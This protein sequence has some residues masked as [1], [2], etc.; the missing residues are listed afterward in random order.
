MRVAQFVIAAFALITSATLFAQSP[1]APA[2]APEPITIGNAH[3]LTTHG[4]QRRINVL[5]PTDYNVSDKVYPLVVMLD[6]GTAQD[7]FLQFGIHRWNQ[8]WGRSEEAI[9]VGVETVDRQRELLP[10]SNNAE[11]TKRYPSH[12]QAD[13]FRAW[14]K[15]EV[16]P[17]IRETYRHDGRSFLVGESAAGH[18]VAET[19]VRTPALFDGYAALSPSLQ[20]NDQSL[21]RDPRVSEAIARPPMFVSLANERG[22]TQEGV[23]RFVSSS[24]SSVCF[25]DRR[26][27]H[28]CHSN[29]LH[30]LLPQALQFLLPTDAD[31]LAQYGMELDCE[32][33]DAANS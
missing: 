11:D 13:L 2:Q 25:A 5:L 22:A 19:W 26:A 20:W 7:L 28:V 10:I 24:K 12:G 33:T 8:L 17:L 4:A 21:S 29:S 6:G 30:Q 14:L 9:I 32:L 16:L 3:T 18:F 1:V 15:D 23:L 27:S 31:W